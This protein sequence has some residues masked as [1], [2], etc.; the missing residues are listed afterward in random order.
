MMGRDIFEYDKMKKVA[1][2]TAIEQLKL[3]G[4][5]AVWASKFDR[6]DVLIKNKDVRIKIK[7]SKPIRR[8]SAVELC[9]EFTKVI[10]KSRLWPHDIYHYYLLMGLNENGGVN[11][12]WKIST[13]EDIIYRKNQIFIPLNKN[14]YYN[15][16]ELKII[17]CDNGQLQWIE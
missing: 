7:F 14:E 5:D 3:R 11:K 1:T 13:D 15:K 9:W 12:L 8:S 6:Y 16:Y 17:D 4:E 2:M 10:H